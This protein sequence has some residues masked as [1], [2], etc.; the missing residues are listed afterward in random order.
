M[1]CLEQIKELTD[2]KEIS[3]KEEQ[4]LMQIANNLKIS[5]NPVFTFVEPINVG[6]FFDWIKGYDNLANSLPSVTSKGV[7]S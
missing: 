3:D 6:L 1:T 5:N 7:V 4:E 2:I